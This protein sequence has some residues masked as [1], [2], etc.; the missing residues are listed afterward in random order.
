[1]IKLLKVSFC[2][3]NTNY[4]AK[5][6]EK[7][8]KVS[9]LLKNLQK[10]P[11]WSFWLFLHGIN[12]CCRI[13][14]SESILTLLVFNF[15]MSGASIFCTSL[16]SVFS[17]T[18]STDLDHYYCILQLKMVQRWHRILF[19]HSKNARWQKTTI[20]WCPWN[21][22]WCKSSSLTFIRGRTQITLGVIHKPCG[23]I[24]GLF[25]PPLPPLWTDMVFWLTPP[26]NH[27]DFR[28]TPPQ[29]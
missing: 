18:Q 8:Q 2:I 12:F 3:W 25:W 16:F 23:R 21:S 22:H 4:E 6:K 1:M 26:K 11:N 19:V 29:R 24:F 15:S 10:V 7:V 20:F 28:R 9:K 13:S 5:F 14:M 27:V 17:S